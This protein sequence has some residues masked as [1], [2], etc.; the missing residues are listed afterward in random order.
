MFH[1][2]GYLDRQTY[3]AKEFITAWSL[4]KEK[5]MCYFWCV[6]KKPAGRNGSSEGSIFWQELESWFYGELVKKLG[7]GKA[8]LERELERLGRR[9]ERGGSADEAKKNAP[10]LCLYYQGQIYTYGVEKDGI[11]AM[12]GHK[13]IY[14]WVRRAG[15]ESKSAE[16]GGILPGTESFFTEA[17]GTMEE[18]ANNLQTKLLKAMSAGILEKSFFFLWEDRDDF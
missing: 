15:A 2:E 4:Q 18:Q 12:E 9:L 11:W 3:A 1:T 8:E 6:W 16:E 7:K 14:L 5:S 10:F 13:G 17:S